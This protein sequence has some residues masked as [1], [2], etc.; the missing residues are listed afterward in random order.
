MALSLSNSQDS[1]KRF[2][3][4]FRMHNTCCWIFIQKNNP[5]LEFSLVGNIFGMNTFGFSP[6]SLN[7]SKNEKFISSGI[8]QCILF[9]L[10]LAQVSL[11]YRPISFPQSNFKLGI[12][13]NKDGLILIV[14]LM[15]SNRELKPLNVGRYLVCD[16]LQTSFLG[17]EIRKGHKDHTQIRQVL[18]SVHNN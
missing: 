6:F 12:I 1:W 17:S 16:L 18:K 15:Q 5:F 10:Y 11:T 4:E 8:E 13:T 3:S 14:N 7:V 9:M 2:F